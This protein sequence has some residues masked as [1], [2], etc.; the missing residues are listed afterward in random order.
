MKRLSDVTSYL[1]D[2]H[3]IIS[4]EKEWITIFKRLPEFEVLIDN[5]K[6]LHL[7]SKET[8]KNE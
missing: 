8:I 7:I 2:D 5:K 6:R 1:F 3:I 4:F